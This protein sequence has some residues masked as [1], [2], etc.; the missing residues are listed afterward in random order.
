MKKSVFFFALFTDLYVSSL[1]TSRLCHRRNLLRRQSI[2]LIHKAVDF[3]FFFARVHC[4][5]VQ[6]SN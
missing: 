1:H 5:F 3:C 6:F 2:Q 4:Y